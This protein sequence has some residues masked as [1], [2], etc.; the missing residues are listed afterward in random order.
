[1]WWWILAGIAALFVVSLALGEVLGWF[2]DNT[3]VSTQY[4]ELIKERLANGNYRVVAGV[5]DKRGVR[6]AKNA[7]ETE[8]LDED[9]EE[10][11]GHRNRIRVEL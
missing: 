6:T 2:D 3:T 1:M 4:G 5:F 10:Y 7:W 11:F 8:E 9:L